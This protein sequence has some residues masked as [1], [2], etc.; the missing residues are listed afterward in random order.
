ML[1]M[2]FKTSFSQF[3]NSWLRSL[4]W[5]ILGIAYR[6]LF[7]FIFLHHPLQ[8][9]FLFFSF[10]C[11]VHWRANWSMQFFFILCHYLLQNLIFFSLLFRSFLF[12]LIFLKIIDMTKLFQILCLPFFSLL[13]LL[14]II[15]VTIDYFEII[16]VVGSRLSAE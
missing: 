1:R 4:L 14:F 3:S 9:F 8:F 16:L 15:V 11:L 13:F 2:L 10:F 5:F 12:R 6:L 7:L